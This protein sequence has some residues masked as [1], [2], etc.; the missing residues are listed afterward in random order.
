MRYIKQPPHHHKP[1]RDSKEPNHE[2][3]K[4]CG[5]IMH[6]G[7]WQRNDALVKEHKKINQLTVVFCPACRKE[8]DG[9]I[10][11]VLTVDR[12]I[13]DADSKEIIN[14]IR[15]IEKQEFS[16]DPLKRITGIVKSKEKII[17]NTLT[18]ELA[19]TIGKKLKHS[20]KGK[21]E[22]HYSPHEDFAEVFLKAIK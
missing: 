2:F 11:G 16:R 4:R 3:C 18:K 22:I 5:I 9:T 8:K 1:S 10:D 12:A 13:F 6:R 19:V 7:R 15:N 20:R 17:V 21:L 14:E